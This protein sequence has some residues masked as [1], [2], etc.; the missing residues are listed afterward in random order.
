MGFEA[1]VAL[2][3]ARILLSIGFGI[4]IGM[5]MSYLFRRRNPTRGSTSGQRIIQPECDNTPDGMDC[6]LLLIAVLIVGTLQVTL[7]T[8]T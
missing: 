5:I 7:L 3:L 8:N 1:D 4:L 2:A 6:F